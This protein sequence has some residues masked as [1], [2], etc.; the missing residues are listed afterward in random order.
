MIKKVKKNEQN[1]NVEVSSSTNVEQNK[2]INNVEAKTT[3]SVEQDIVLDQLKT[4]EISKPIEEMSQPDSIKESTNETTS[5]TFD[6]DVVYSSAAAQKEHIKNL[7]LQVRNETLIEKERIAAEKQKLQQAIIEIELKL[8]KSKVNQVKTLERAKLQEAKIIEEANKAR[9][10]EEEELRKR[11]ELVKQRSRDISLLNEQ[12]QKKQLLLA[13]E[14]ASKKAEANQQLKLAQIKILE[15]LEAKKREARIK[16]EEQ[17]AAALEVLNQ[18]KQER[19]RVKAEKIAEKN[20]HKQEIEQMKLELFAEKN[21]AKAELYAKR[22][23]AKTK[24]LEELERA[25]HQTILLK[26][27]RAKAIEAAK[28]S[29]IKASI[30]AEK[31]KNK[32]AQ[33]IM[34]ETI[35]IEN[36]REE[37]EAEVEAL[38][39]VNDLEIKAIQNANDI[40]IQKTTMVDLTS[41]V[42]NNLSKEEQ[43]LKIFKQDYV[44]LVSEF[45]GFDKRGDAQLILM[46]KPVSEK[47]KKKFLAHHYYGPLV[48]KYIEIEE[49]GNFISLSHMVKYAHIISEDELNFELINAKVKTLQ[50]AILQGIPIK[51]G[52]YYIM[53]I[54]K[55]GIKSFY[56]S[57]HLKD[58]EVIFDNNKLF[59]PSTSKGIEEIIDFKFEQGASLKICNGLAIANDEGSLSIVVYPN[60]LN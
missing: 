4:V 9:A 18:V 6:K 21:R 60:I 31:K 15:E 59:S 39:E 29:R 47:K 34:D 42:A 30:E 22:M 3:T 57:H 11:T 50:K 51:V 8:Q 41:E 49:S 55:A 7:R 23:E 48:K 28:L 2:N 1:N 20:A 54:N 33:Q 16:Q 58:G 52:K 38:K 40:L 14:I 12:H 43:A 46:N 45:K 13:Q 24:T 37:N 25:K 32:L 19:E 44:T 36:I 26:D 27:E 35:E 10:I 17:K 5:I 56:I 53:P